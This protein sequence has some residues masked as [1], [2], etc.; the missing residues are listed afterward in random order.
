MLAI[1][2]VQDGFDAV[3]LAIN[4]SIAHIIKLAFG[5]R[6][7]MMTKTAPKQQI[8]ARKPR[9]ARAQQKVELILEAAIRLLE[10]GGLAALT[11]N[12]VAELA[13]VSIGTLYQYFSN[14]EAILD[15]LAASEMAA[16]AARIREV[17]TDPSIISPE[18]RV[19]AVVG[20]VATSYGERQ[21]AHR[22]VMEHSL[23]RGGSR[24]SP[25][26]SELIEDFSHHQRDGALR[27][28]LANADAFV[29]IHAF[30]GVL[31]AM[32]QQADAP[33]RTEIEKALTRLVTH[34]VADGP[35]ASSR[36]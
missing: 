10:N 28:P 27:E 34:F 32:T 7:M 8:G 15:A 30:A 16:M 33:P 21:G 35:A 5:W 36:Q 25:F 19:A 17:L 23:A 20:A 12:A 31:R 4:M 22:L 9:Q 26:L 13:G 1:L 2:N 11:T 18:A 14:K 24:M 3:T 29:L 6:S